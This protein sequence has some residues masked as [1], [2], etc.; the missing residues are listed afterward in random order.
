MAP[1]KRSKRTIIIHRNV[2]AK[3]EQADIF[4]MRKT[5][6]M[7]LTTQKAPPNFRIAGI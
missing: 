5:I 7:H 2:D 1:H 4:E 3:N 6:N